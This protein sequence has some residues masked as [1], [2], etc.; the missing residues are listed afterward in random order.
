MT[1]SSSASVCWYTSEAGLCS[2]GVYL[3]SFRFWDPLDRLVHIPQKT[4][5]YTPISK[6]KTMFPLL[7]AGAEHIVEANKRVRAD[8]ALCEAFGCAPCDQ[9]VLQD[10]LSACTEETVEQFHEASRLI[11]QQF[12]KAGRHNFRKRMLTLDLDLTG[13]TCGKT[14]ESATKGYFVRQKGK[15]GRQSARVLASDYNEIVHDAVYA[16]TV[17]L[18]PIMMDLVQ[19][20][21]SVLGLTPDQKSR[22]LIRTDGGGGTK[23]VVEWLVESG[24]PFITK[25]FAWHT[26]DAL[27]RKV[28][29]WVDDPRT[30]GRQVGLVPRGDEDGLPENVTMVGMR[31]TKDDGKEGGAVIMSSLSAKEVIALVGWSPAHAFDPD[32]VVLAYTL[33]YDR[34]GGGI[35][36]SFKEDK[37][38][39]ALGKL[40]KREMA[41]QQI[42]N[43]IIA[44]AHNIIV[45][46]N[47]WLS[48]VVPDLRQ[49]GILRMV[50]DIL[51]VRGCVSI[52]KRSNKVC[53]TLGSREPHAKKVQRAFEGLF[54]PKIAVVRL[55]EI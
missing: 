23:K 27:K 17:Q 7:L 12:S 53:I 22:T 14:A 20:A 33:L 4:V 19:S 45:W 49:F 34:R 55:G 31:F 51:G 47:A 38:G 26:V 8:P 36:T 24:Y 29:H 16:G 9:S 28:E 52:R 13:L 21:A 40:N 5:I 25:T 54:A 37:Q 35:E 3:N 11:F 1:K 2:L 18:G 30:T 43:A 15:T 41:A 39:L 46:A 44:L 32:R 50:R 42:V 10:T 48:D 6:L